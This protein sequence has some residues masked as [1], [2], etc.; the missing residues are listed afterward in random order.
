MHNQTE[1][2]LLFRVEPF[3]KTPQFDVSKNTLPQGNVQTK[4][5]APN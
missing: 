1:L 5:K 2:T 3:P 4:I